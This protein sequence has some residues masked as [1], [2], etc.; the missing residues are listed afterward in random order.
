MRAAHAG[1]TG[2]DVC[3]PASR[4]APT[5]SIIDLATVDHR[6]QRCGSVQV[7]LKARST[8]RRTATR[9]GCPRSSFRPTVTPKYRS[10][11]RRGGRAPCIRLRGSLRCRGISTAAAPARRVGSGSRVLF[12]TTKAG[13]LSIRGDPAH[14]GVGI[15]SRPRAGGLPDI[16]VTAETSHLPRR[17]GAPAAPF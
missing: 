1:P 11:V 12:A 2:K 13:V 8:T 7:V 9:A 4:A 14:A 3:A 5:M 6:V 15:G 10:P 16:G 17:R